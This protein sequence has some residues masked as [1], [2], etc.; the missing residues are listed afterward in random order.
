[1]VYLKTILDLTLGMA[2]MILLVRMTGKKSL[3]D[4][5]PFDVIYLLMI[6]GILEQVLY[7]EKRPI[8]Y[9]LWGFIVWGVLILIVERW[10]FKS[11]RYRHKL[12]GRPAV[13]I[14][15]GV[16]NFKE[17]KRNHIELEQLRTIM[18]Q[19]GCFSLRNVDQLI[20]E[21]NGRG[22]IIRKTEVKDYLS[23]LLID[24]GEP[25]P[26]TLETLEKD[27]EWLTNCLNE[28][29]FEELSDILYCEWTKEEGFYVQTYVEAEGKEV[30]IDG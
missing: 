3:S 8:T 19:E 20:F 17:L 11:D 9:V 12:K 21:I 16:L 10:A 15:N 7:E 22:S 28:E 13:L 29:G 26:K 30:Y 23:Y 4:L 27:E 25:E 6:G 18:R 2:G 14:W 5:T 24:E 1:M